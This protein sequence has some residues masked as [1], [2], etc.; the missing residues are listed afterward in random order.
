MNKKL[1]ELYR[2]ATVCLVFLQF[3]LFTPLFTI[4]QD[5]MDY[6]A[7][8]EE[9][10]SFGLIENGQPVPVVLG[11][12]D[13]SGVKSVAE[14]F[15]ND[16]NSITGQTPAISTANSSLPEEIILVG[17]LGKNELIDQ[18]IRAG[19][20]D[21]SDI[22]DQWECSLTQVVEN[23]FPGVKKALVLAGSD[24]RG[25]IYAMLNLSR[26]M[27]VSPW[28]WW[29]DVPVEKKDQLY[30]KAGRWVTESPKVK[31]RGIFLNDEEPALGNW[32][33]EKFGGINHKFYAH[34]FE[35]ILRLR[36]NFMWPAMWGKAFYDDD[37]ANGPLAD[38]LG[39][40]MSTSHHEPLGRAQAEWHKYGSGP[41]DYTKNKD[42]LSDF[43]QKGMER[44]K[45]WETIVTVGM[46]GDG[47]EA[48]EEG[49]N[50][51]LLENIVNEQRKIISDVTGKKPEETPQ[52]WALYK[53][54]QDYYDNGMR[55]P[56]DVTLLLCDDNWGDVRKL[57]DVNAPKHE[58][59]FGMYYH[60]DY[61]GG[62]RNYKWINVTQIQR[63]WEQMNLTYSHGV[64]RIWV[65]NVGD[66]KPME[67]PISFFLEMAWDPTQFNPN[68]LK[69]YIK[70]WSAEQFGE[71][72]A[73][74]AAR[75]LNQYTKFNHR[76]TP[77]LLNA[78]TYS[79][80]NYNE[81]ERVRN[82]YRDLAFD[83]LR[84][85]NLIP[86]AYKDAFDQLVLFPTN[87]T[88]NLYEMYYAVAK[89]KQLIANNDIEANYWA[90]V[91]ETCFKRDSALTVHYNQQIAGGKWN[92]MMDQIRIGYTYWQEPR[93]AKMPAVERV[94]IPE[95]L[96][97]EL[98]FKETDGYVS[99]EAE[100]YQ[101]AKGTET[102]TWEVIPDLGKTAS[103]V[104]T[105]P[106]NAYPGENDKVYLE[107]AVDFT[108]TGDF[109]VHVLVSPTLNFNANK[110]LRYAVSFDEGQEQVV[111]INGKY[112]GELGPWQANRIIKTITNHKINKEGIHRLRIRVLEP[113]IVFQ[114]IMIDTGGLK[115]SFLGAPESKQV[116][117]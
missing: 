27:G 40:V 31:Y 75:I 19:K 97:K 66:L 52:V 21:A 68:N 44:N 83:A 73:D 35:L 18:L 71:N 93:Q 69:D 110:G 60:F 24:K 28:Y 95:V 45:D 102:I 63:V 58:G 108:S 8:T 70:N 11:Q 20:I 26:E 94:E 2:V 56:D 23:P 104:T 10:G 1:F 41:W 4:A 112:R 15:V 86:N 88:A 36:G 16:I 99:I 54:V 6:I 9:E 37:P 90:D 81:F 13:F 106:Q 25:T 22:A 109:E 72:Y 3:A 117:F 91:V 61:V 59:G 89:N 47:D 43:W 114:K 5:R 82:E 33:R 92:H 53:E 77:E 30:V 65:V 50:I 49:T 46:R 100:N 7:S 85:Y 62:P 79:I 38:K 103:A 57:P 51:A 105:F 113:G 116:K 14:W 34:V 111:N 98:A 29:A 67:Y 115:P 17:T 39:I 87:A 96:N 74:E 55:V 42:V 84:L 64:D 107:Y 101:K 48:M 78:R 80:E 32:A 76:V 12:N